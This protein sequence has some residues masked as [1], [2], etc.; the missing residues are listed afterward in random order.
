MKRKI[1]IL[2]LLFSASCVVAQEGISELQKSDVA[3]GDDV[4][5]KGIDFGISLGFNSAFST[6]YDARISPLDNRLKIT[7]VPRTAF[8]ISTG[9]SVPL[10]RKNRL[11]GRYYRK[12][13]DGE[14]T[15]PVYYVPFGWCLIA[16]VNIIT[17]NSAASGSAF[18]QKIDG[19]FGIGYKISD[20]LQL[21]VTG[22]M[23][24][25]RQPRQFLLDGYNDKILTAP[26]GEVISSINPDDNNYFRDKYMPAISFKFFYLFSYKPLK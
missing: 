25:Y 8:M 9:I 21:A 12:L 7:K 5:F 23:I 15:G 20:N 16:T 24:S 22:E 4:V 19:G 6:I 26:T 1:F 2:S 10:T 18:N 17:F 11:N 13:V 3:P 14:P